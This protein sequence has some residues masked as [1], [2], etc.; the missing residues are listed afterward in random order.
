MINITKKKKDE[1]N[2]LLLV[3]NKELNSLTRMVHLTENGFIPLS[4]RIL[5]KIQN[6]PTKPEEIQVKKTTKIVK[7]TF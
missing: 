5:N 1:L 4:V 6:N 2:S 7:P 3:K